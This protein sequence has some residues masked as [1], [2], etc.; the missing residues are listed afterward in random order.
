MGVPAND[1]SK[2]LLDLLLIAKWRSHCNNNDIVARRLDLKYK[3]PTIIPAVYDKIIL[4]FVK[5]WSYIQTPLLSYFWGVRMGRG[6]RFV[7]KTFV[8]SHGEGIEIG[9][10]V[11]FNSCKRGN[12]VGLTGPTIID[13]RFGGKIS[14]GHG[15]GFSSVVISSKSEVSIGDRVLVGGNVRIYDHDFHS[16][17]SRIRGSAHDAENIRT[18]AVH[19]A[20]DCFIGTGAVILKGTDLGAR[21]IV[22]A[23]SV[24]FGLST[25]PDS[26][27]KGNPAVIVRSAN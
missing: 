20:N 26:L 9:D 13:N 3:F 8:R 1:I 19:I 17:D 7:G 10:R 22:A 27:V 21:T 5:L 14:I 16:L 24:V 6:S 25:P 12:L 15:S 23:G 2:R 11:I 18:R 4:K